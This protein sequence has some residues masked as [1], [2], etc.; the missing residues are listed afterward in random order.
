MEELLWQFK[1]LNAFTYWTTAVF[2]GAVVW[3]I[4]EIVNAS[5]LAIFSAPI[6]FFG[7][8]LSNLLF[9]QQMITL[10]ADKD[11]NV[12]AISAIGVLTALLFIVA[13]KWL[14]YVWKERSVR[15]TKLVH[16]SDVPGSKTRRV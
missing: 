3:F 7:G 10:I 12:A 8:V 16:A 14:W 6:L 13:G 9:Q 11:A 1:D 15:N 2:A 5:T 4:K